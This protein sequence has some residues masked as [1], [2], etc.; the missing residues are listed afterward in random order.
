MKKLLI[1]STLIFAPL[2]AM[3]ESTTL[4]PDTENKWQLYISGNGGVMVSDVRIKH[5]DFLDFGTQGFFAVGGRN[6]RYRT[7]LAY[8]FHAEMSELFQILAG[9][10][11]TLGNASVRINGYYDYV[12]TK[13][14]A[15]FIGG[16]LG[17]NFYN[18]TIS[19]PYLN[20]ETKKEGVSFIMGADTGLSF[21]IWKF[22]IDV[23]FGFDYI[24]FPRV[25]SYGPNVGL[26]F[27]F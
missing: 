9:H 12:H 26:R 5:D 8:E 6:N 20:R 7:E 15:M 10:M 19:E 21:N 14:F 17:P 13:H 3:A 1:Y 25:Y 11:V 2:S 16:G 24:T 4:N 22:S 18:Y 23:G 27:T